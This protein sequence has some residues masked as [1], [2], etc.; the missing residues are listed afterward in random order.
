M[1]NIIIISLIFLSAGYL[2]AQVDDS[3][4]VKSKV[5]VHDQVQVKLKNQSSDS[6]QFKNGNRIEVQNKNQFGHTDQS[7]N[8]DKYKRK[9]DVFVD[10]D[11]DGINDNRVSGMSFSK[12][13]KRYQNKQSGHGGSGNNNNNGQGQGGWKIFN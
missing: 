1:K 4:K 2:T 5:Q 8:S 9:K 6:L 13:R 12:I 3:L 10:K 11:G 7:I